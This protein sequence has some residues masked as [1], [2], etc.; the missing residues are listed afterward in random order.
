M[1]IKKIFAGVTTVTCAV[2]M[3]GGSFAPVYAETLA[4]IEA[5]LAE[6]TELLAEYQAMYAELVGDTPG[7]PASYEGI[8]D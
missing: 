6:L 7:T 2:M 4:E 3:L 5:K 8:P 1:S